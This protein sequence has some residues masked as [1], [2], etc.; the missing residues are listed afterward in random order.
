MD[1]GGKINFLMYLPAKL[2]EFLYQMLPVLAIVLILNS[3][4]IFAENDDYK[5]EISRKNCDKS[6]FIDLLI[7]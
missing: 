6:E 4:T 5:R 2:D 1:D 3:L 7:Y